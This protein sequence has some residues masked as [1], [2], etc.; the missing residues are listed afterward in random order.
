MDQDDYI[1]KGECFE[2]MNKHLEAIENYKK[3]LDGLGNEKNDKS[4]KL[5]MKLGELYRNSGDMDSCLEYFKMSYEIAVNLDNIYFKIDALNKLAM[6][7]FY[8][9]EIG[10]SLTYINKSSNLLNEADYTEGKLNNLI[11]WISKYFCEN[12]Y[13]KAREI[14]NAALKLCGKNYPYYRGRFLNII[15]QSLTDITDADEELNLLKLSLKS[16]EEAGFTQGVL[17]VTSNIGAVYT[18]KLQD[19]EKAFQVYAELKNK[20]KKENF[21]EFVVIS[22]IDIGETYLSMLKY[23]K[24]YISYKNGLKT[25]KKIKLDHMTFYAYI[26][27]LHS[28]IKLEKYREAYKYFK[29]ANDEFCKNP[30]QGQ[31][32][33]LYYKV[34]S[35]FYYKLGDMGNAKKNSKLSLRFLTIDSVIK[36]NAGLVY[37]FIRLQDAKNNMEIN[38]ALEGIKGLLSMYKS[39]EFIMNI[40]YNSVICLLDKGYEDEA[41]RMFNEYKDIKV[42]PDLL[43][44]YIEAYIKRTKDMESLS[45]INKLEASAEANGGSLLWKVYLLI[46]DYYFKES[47][48]T[49][50]SYYEK[51]LIEADKFLN[52]VPKEYKDSFSKTY[53]LD[54]PRNK[55]I[56]IEKFLKS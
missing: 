32:I 31:S 6:E 52:R 17:G 3:A 4:F 16:F 28:C 46:G 19:N 44:L 5:N 1:K 12:E 43:R 7:N 23:D 34:I 56:F 25:A 49:A 54:K 8:K 33:S 36:W 11:Y 38:E 21:N 24:A 18:D 53:N 10:I 2:K 41:I 39:I 15:A 45:E 51:S 20:A 40:V 27:L 37:E 47:I 29:L 13:Y 48:L 26:G 50:A 35:L 14:G 9:G 55:L 42:K 22:Y 30:E